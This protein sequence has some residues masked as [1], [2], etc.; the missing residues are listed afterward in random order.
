MKTWKKKQPEGKCQTI[1]IILEVYIGRPSSIDSLIFLLRTGGGA[2]RVFP[3]DWGSALTT[4]RT[5]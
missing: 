3:I 1:L 4:K 5:Y 2:R